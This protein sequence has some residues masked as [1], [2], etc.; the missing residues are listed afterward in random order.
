LIRLRRSGLGWCGKRG[1]KGDAALRQ[2]AELSAGRGNFA[3]RATAMFRAG[4]VRV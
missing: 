1:F 4:F 2:R 3:R